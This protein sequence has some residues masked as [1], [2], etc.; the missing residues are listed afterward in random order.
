MS[1]KYRIAITIL[2]LEA[3]MVA[4]LLWSTLSFTMARSREQF[5]QTHQV[6]LDFL[7]D[8]SISALI[9]ENYGVLQDYVERLSD[10]PQIHL[11]LVA[12]HNQRIIAS[13]Q[14]E[15]LGDPLDISLNDPD[16][17]WI[18]RDLGASAGSLGQVAVEF[19]LAPLQ[20]VSDA[21]R[22]LGLRI[23]LSG[24]I[25]IAVVGLVMGA[26]LTRRLARL[27]AAARRLAAGERDVRLDLRGSDEVARLAQSF[28]DM[29][30]T[31]R[32]T[33]EALET[34][35][36]QFRG[37]LEGSI[38][39]VLVHRHFRPLYVNP[40]FA[41]ML[42]YDAPDDLYALGSAL[43]LFA[44]HEHE[45]IQQYNQARLQ[46]QPEA[47]ALYE[48]EAVR[49]DGAARWFECLSQ[50]I[51]WRGEAAVQS[52]YVD[53]S[54]RKQAE[55]DRERL[56][57][58]LRRSQ[59]MEAIGVLAGGIA[60]EFNNLLGG[61]VGFADLIRFDVRPGSD[62]D[63]HAQQILQAGW[64]AKELVKQILAF[65][66]RG[67]PETLQTVSLTRVVRD[68]LPLLQAS[69][70]STIAIHS[71]L[72]QATT[73]VLANANELHQVLLNLCANAGH[74]MRERGGRLD[75]QVDACLLT[76]P[77]GSGYLPVEPGPYVLLCVSD[78]GCGMSQV[79]VERIFEPFFT[80]KAVGEGTGMG[81]SIAHSIIESYSGAMT[82]ES[83]PDVGTT[84]AI[85]LPAHEQAEVVS[86]AAKL[87]PPQGH[88]RILVVDDEAFLVRATEQLL[89]RLGYDA[90]A[91]ANSVE[92]LNFFRA[93]PHG[94][95][96]VLTDQTM[97][98]MTGEELARAIRELRADIPII[99][100]SGFSRG[101]TMEQLQDLK[102]DAFCMKPLGA[103]ELATTL[104]QLLGQGA[105][106]H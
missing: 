66:R 37:L 74:A 89:K 78:T 81:L 95:D 45:R 26:T 58:Q 77:E 47:P 40:A 46:Q 8:I 51:E 60:H 14:I 82:V 88:G 84:V 13:N 20:E 99:L 42:G 34:R 21:A 106:C 5:R 56:E 92:A 96:A 63:E 97:P 2:L 9:T 72:T 87:A 94:F 85:Y 70:P 90:A 33:V 55:A 80:T 73:T 10:D 4:L 31:I 23:A 22:R 91:T 67:Q 11:A 44:P 50:R 57:A 64:R 19:S 75:I 43:P 86:E 103:Y 76:H 12:D 100:C 102:I 29:A 98:Q 30:R 17:F 15:R 25:I 6:T 28:N 54:D 49:Q 7:G 59:K 48:I 16:H 24:M 41:A 36:Q 68:A 61:I 65:S 101:P 35:E 83:K 93:D 3:V 79:V 1:Q 62:V 38:Q 71:H 104:H 69:L 53:I 27:G 18:A 39:G 32:R 52:I 105:C